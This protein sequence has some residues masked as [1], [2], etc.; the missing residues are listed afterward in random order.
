MCRASE[1]NL[2]CKELG[3]ISVVAVGENQG[4]QNGGR[5]GLV[6]EG[7]RCLKFGTKVGLFCWGKERNQSTGTGFFPLP[8]QLLDCMFVFRADCQYGQIRIVDCG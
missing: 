8:Y 5:N 6:V 7:R 1:R 3:Q 4:A 2:E